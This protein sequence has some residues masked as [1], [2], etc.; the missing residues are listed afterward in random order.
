M[1]TSN[2]CPECGSPLPPDAPRGFCPQCLMK[3]GMTSAD[4]GFEGDEE[5]LLSLEDPS[6][7][8]VFLGEQGRGGMGRVLLSTTNAW[9]GTSR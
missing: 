6:D 3:R 9:E 5:S 8:Y 2:T 1:S 4:A 7:R